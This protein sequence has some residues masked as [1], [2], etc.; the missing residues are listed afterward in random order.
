MLCILIT[1]SQ[2]KPSADQTCYGSKLTG[3]AAIYGGAE[4]KSVLAS[5][6]DGK[7]WSVYLKFPSSQTEQLA[8]AFREKFGEPSKHTTSQVTS[9]AGATFDNFVSE[10][11]NE[12]GSIRI[13]KRASNVTEGSVTILTTAGREERKRRQEAATASNAKKL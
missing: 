5:F 10:W 6:Y 9:R 8:D 7:L 13:E 3:E 11:I 2:F 1:E 4:V 12:E